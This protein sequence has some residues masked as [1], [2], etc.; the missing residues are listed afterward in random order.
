MPR[1]SAIKIQIGV[2]L[3]RGADISERSLE[4]VKRGIDE[5]WIEWVFVHGFDGE[6]RCR[7]EA[8][9]HID[10][11]RYQVS[12]DLGHMDINISES[13]RD[14]V[15]PEVQES[16]AEFVLFCKANSLRREWRVQYSALGNS[17]SDHV[18]RELGF[19]TAEPLD[20][21]GE[22]V[23]F[24]FRI[25]EIDELTGWVKFVG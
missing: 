4:K 7:A 12:I 10:W 23:P 9:L 14:N 24:E 17:M 11:H 8:A 16:I 5:R 20:W 15:A 13:W 2:A 6:S 18:D 22:P 3:R 1:L 21:A 25:R 19:S